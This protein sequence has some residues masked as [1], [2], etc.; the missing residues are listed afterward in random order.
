MLATWFDSLGGDRRM[1]ALVI[2][3]EEVVRELFGM[4]LRRNGYEVLL[5]GDGGTGLTF[6]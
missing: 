5:A 2:D 1:S 6:A 4:L 3:D